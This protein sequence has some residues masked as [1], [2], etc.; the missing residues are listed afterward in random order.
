MV[1][2]KLI[3]SFVFTPEFDGLFL[4]NGP[5]DPVRCQSTISNIRRILNETSPKPVFG[6]CLGHQLMS[7]AVGGKIVKMR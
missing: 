1:A 5:G 6:I 7:L 4:S 3:S 2:Y